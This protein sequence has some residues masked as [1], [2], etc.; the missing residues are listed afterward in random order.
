LFESLPVCSKSFEFYC[1]TDKQ[2]IT[3]E[4]EDSDEEPLPPPPITKETL[5]K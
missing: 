1:L 5:E 3:F 2:T 4:L